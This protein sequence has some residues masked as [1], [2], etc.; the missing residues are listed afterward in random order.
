MHF[1]GLR[2]FYPEPGAGSPFRKNAR[3][4]VLKMGLAILLSD[5]RNIVI[6]VL[7]LTLAFVYFNNSESNKYEKEALEKNENEEGT[8]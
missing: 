1:F 5:K 4:L 7:I 6:T 2:L 3:K 8:F